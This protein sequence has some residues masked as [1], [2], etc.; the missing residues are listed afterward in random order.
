MEITTRLSLNVEVFRVRKN[1]RSHSH[2][3]CQVT[4]T[5]WKKKKNLHFFPQS[6]VKTLLGFQ[7]VCKAQNEKDGKNQ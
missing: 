2:P 3:N 5:R 4:V 1:I 7:Q 6:Q